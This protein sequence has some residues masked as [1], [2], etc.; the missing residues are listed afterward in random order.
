MD[1]FTSASTSQGM[2]KAFKD[3]QLEIPNIPCAVI[4]P[5][6]YSAAIKRGFNIKAVAD[7]HTVDGL[8]G[9]D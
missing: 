9:Y 2:E 7:P 3:H 5:V 6:T 4:G 1:C 8:M